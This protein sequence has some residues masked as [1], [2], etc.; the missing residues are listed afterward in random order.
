MA[1]ISNGLTRTVKVIKDLS[2]K[3]ESLE[4][5]GVDL[6]NYPTKTEVNTGIA[7]GVSDAKAYT[8][9]RE[10]AIKTA[11]N[12]AI[13]DAITALKGVAPET[14]D[15]LEEIAKAFDNNPDII[16]SLVTQ[17]GTKAS[18]TDLT[19]HTSK[20]DIH[21]TSAQKTEWSGKVSTSQL[22]SATTVSDS[23]LSAWLTTQAGA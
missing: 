20:A 12:N 22:T 2:S 17:M 6:T 10:I 13:N 11:Y 7:I 21:V 15:T 18:T 9:G 5:N 8:D 16:K 3:V 23:T 14:L 4:N 1:T 19:S